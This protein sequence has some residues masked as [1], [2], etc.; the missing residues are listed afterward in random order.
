MWFCDRVGYSY[1]WIDA[2][3]IIQEDVEDWTKEAAMM[4]AGYA[5]AAFTISAVGAENCNDSLF[6]GRSAQYNSCEPTRVMVNLSSAD[7]EFD[8]P[9]TIEGEHKNTKEDL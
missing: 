7:N 1:L 4:D 2:L 3:C 9:F 6:A 8:V 5:G